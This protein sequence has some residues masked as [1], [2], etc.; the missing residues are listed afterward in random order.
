MK[1]PVNALLRLM[2]VAIVAALGFASYARGETSF[3]NRG[4]VDVEVAGDVLLAIGTDGELLRSTN[5]GVVFSVKFTPDPFEKPQALAVSGQIAIA[6]CEGGV[7]LRSTDAGSTW[8]E[9]N[10]PLDFAT[11]NSVDS[12]GS[13]NW[14]AVGQSTGQCYVLRSTDGGQNW[15]EVSISQEGSFE[16]VAYDIASKVWMTGG[17]KLSSGRTGIAFR[18]TN[19]TSWTSIA[20]PQDTGSVSAIAASGTGTFGLVG[21]DGFHALMSSDGTILGSDFESVTESL[22][23]IEFTAEGDW[24]A[25]GMESLL[26]RF[27][28]AGE[29]LATTVSQEA[30]AGSP[31]VAAFAENASGTLFIASEVGFEASTPDPK[32]RIYL[33]DG[34]LVIQAT[35]LGLG[36]EY[37]LLKS[38]DLV[39]YEAV[40]ESAVVATGTTIQWVVS[41]EIEETAPVFWKLA[42]N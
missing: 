19:G 9:A 36:R 13:G 3:L 12:D 35:G 38:H 39:N 1:R 23:A 17:W 2:L 22:L 4:L 7:V 21:A 16:T 10:V 37:Y 27:G 25:G 24:I 33:S 20:L 42:E 15:S 6:V 26:I 30:S 28:L 18:S 14:I 32:V 8:S 11:L 29:G 41:Q 31:A 5:D 34:D 40:P